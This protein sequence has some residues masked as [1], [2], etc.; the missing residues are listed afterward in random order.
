M[1]CQDQ[2]R[3]RLPCIALML[4]DSFDLPTDLLTALTSLGISSDF[5]LLFNFGS[6]LE[7]WRRLPP[8]LISL[9]EF[10]R[11]TKDALAQASAVGVTCDKLYAQAVESSQMKLGLPALDAVLGGVFGPRRVLEI[12]GDHGSGKSVRFLFNANHLYLSLNL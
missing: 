5:D 8:G 9:Q 7:I 12:S 3:F 6:S 10:E 4:L 2:L 1:L 11:C